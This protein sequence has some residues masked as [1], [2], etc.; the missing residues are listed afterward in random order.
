MTSI[1][2]LRKL[3]KPVLAQYPDLEIYIAELRP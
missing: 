3:F 2:P 1:A